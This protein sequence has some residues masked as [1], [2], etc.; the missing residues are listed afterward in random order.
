[1]AILKYKGSDGNFKPLA[2]IL[3]KGIEVVQEKGQSTA[4]VMSQKAV[5]DAINDA[6]PPADSDNN[7]I[8][9]AGEY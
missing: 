1:M 9:T 3:V 7:V 2:N 8:L 4:D 5:T 6:I